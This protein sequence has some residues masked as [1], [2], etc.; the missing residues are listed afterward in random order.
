MCDMTISGEHDNPDENDEKHQ[1]EHILSENMRMLEDSKESD[2]YG[3]YLSVSSDDDDLL[4]KKEH[5]L[6]M[7]SNKLKPQAKSK[8]TEH[9]R[10]HDIQYKEKARMG[11]V[12]TE[13]D[14]KVDMSKQSTP[15]N[16]RYVNQPA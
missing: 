6:F 3:Y 15:K 10:Q 12:T 4:H 11:M 5:Q 16:V 9:I 14:A 1:L 7:D 2:E 13:D 8:M